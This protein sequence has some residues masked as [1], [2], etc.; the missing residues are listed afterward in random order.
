MIKE[1]Q[2]FCYNCRVWQWWEENK[3]PS[4]TKKTYENVMS[5]TVGAIDA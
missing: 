5:E 4:M 2:D 3:E 1:C